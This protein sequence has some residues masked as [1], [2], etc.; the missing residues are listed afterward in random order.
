MGPCAVYEQT[1]FVTPMPGNAQG[2]GP[3]FDDLVLSLVDPACDQKLEQVKL[4]GD[5][6]HK[7]E[8]RHEDRVAVGNHAHVLHG[9]W[10]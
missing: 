10:P 5:M 7:V 3:P 4:L 8:L 6:Q 9:A 1:P 2:D